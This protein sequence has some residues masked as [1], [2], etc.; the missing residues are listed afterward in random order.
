MDNP[1]LG[2][3]SASANFWAQELRNSP[4]VEWLN[5]GLTAAWSPNLQAARLHAEEGLALGSGFE[6]GEPGGRLL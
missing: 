1:Q 4:V 2:A 3:F 5:K 6:V